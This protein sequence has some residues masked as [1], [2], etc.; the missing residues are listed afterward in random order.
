MARPNLNIERGVYTRS[1]HKTAYW[2]FIILGL[3]F[4]ILG[5]ML[6]LKSDQGYLGLIVPVAFGLLLITAITTKLVIDTNTKSIT[7]SYFFGLFTKKKNG[8]LYNQ[9]QFVDSYLNGQYTGKGI[10]LVNNEDLSIKLS[11]FGPF[12]NEVEFEK[13]QNITIEIVNKLQS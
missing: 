1:V 2:I 13:Y 9:Y 4:I 8:R 10:Y 6:F 3:F 5:I 11:L 7:E 12:K